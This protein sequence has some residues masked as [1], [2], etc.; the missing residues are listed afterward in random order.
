MST[1]SRTAEQ[2]EMELVATLREIRKERKLFIQFGVWAWKK[3]TTLPNDEL[4]KR[5]QSYHLRVKSI[6]PRSITLVAESRD[7]YFKARTF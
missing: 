3:F 7:L 2:M 1:I 4:L 6:T 5:A